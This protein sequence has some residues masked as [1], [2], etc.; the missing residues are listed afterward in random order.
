[1]L[2]VTAQF[3]PK[4]NNGELKMI[5][6]NY[7]LIFEYSITSVQLT[8]LFRLKLLPEP[9]VPFG[10]GGPAIVSISSAL[11]KKSKID[12]KLF[13]CTAGIGSFSNGL[14]Q[15]FYLVLCA[16]P[17]VIFQCTTTCR[18]PVRY[19]TLWHNKKITK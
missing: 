12:E 11:K 6:Y 16:Y 15:N 1:M 7:I 17:T 13:K 14:F 5:N 18:R 19:F 4:N 8:P 2:Q 3:L 9:L 10:F